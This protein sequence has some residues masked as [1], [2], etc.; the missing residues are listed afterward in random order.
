VDPDDVNI[1]V[2]G[3]QDYEEEQSDAY[4]DEDD[5]DRNLNRKTDNMADYKKRVK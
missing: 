3:E 5:E 4:E 2:D 1:I